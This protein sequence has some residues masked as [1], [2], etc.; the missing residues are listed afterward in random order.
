VIWGIKLFGNYGLS[1]QD[2]CDELDEQL[3]VS[4]AA[5]IKTRREAAKL[6]LP[7]IAQPTTSLSSYPMTLFSFPWPLLGHD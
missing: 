3:T 6:I 1:S 7:G 4:G 5:L 2:Y